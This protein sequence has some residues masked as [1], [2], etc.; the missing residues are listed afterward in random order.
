M[1]AEKQYN[2]LRES[3]SIIERWERYRALAALPSALLNLTNEIFSDKYNRAVDTNCKTCLTTAFNLI[4]TLFREYEMENVTAA[5]PDEKKHR[6]YRR[7]KKNLLL[8]QF[9]ICFYCRW[10][11]TFSL[12]KKITSAFYPDEMRAA[13]VV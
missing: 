1:I 4:C 9:S 6:K 7:K 8:P 11:L 12:S 3:I 5:V 13:L 2:Q 10:L